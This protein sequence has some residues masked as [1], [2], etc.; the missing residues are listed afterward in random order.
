[1]DRTGERKNGRKRKGT[2][3]R[4]DILK[5]RKVPQSAVKLQLSLPTCQFQQPGQQ[6]Y[7]SVFDTV[8]N[9]RTKRA[10]KV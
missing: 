5:R 2:A 9:P 3:E 10:R 7:T 1:M 6:P 4:K 8:A